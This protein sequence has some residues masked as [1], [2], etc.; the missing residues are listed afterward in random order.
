MGQEDSANC[1]ELVSVESVGAA[2]SRMII[3]L[4]HPLEISRTSPS[5]TMHGD[6]SGA[7]Q[8]RPGT[9]VREGVVLSALF[10]SSGFD[11]STGIR[12]RS[13]LHSRHVLA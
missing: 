9:C 6:I 1:P 2:R 10:A 5:T 4:F 12:K 3:E 8:L 13:S 11:F 7:L